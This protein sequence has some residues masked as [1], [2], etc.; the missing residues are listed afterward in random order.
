[1]EGGLEEGGGRRKK[2]RERKERKGTNH[3]LKLTTSS[4]VDTRAVFSTIS[5]ESSTMVGVSYIFGQ[6]KEKKG[7]RKELGTQIC[8]FADGAEQQEKGCGFRIETTCCDAMPRSACSV[9][10]TTTG[11]FQIFSTGGKSVRTVSTIAD[12]VNTIGGTQC[13]ITTHVVVQLSDEG[14]ICC[15]Q[16]KPSLLTALL[17][18]QK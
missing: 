10:V 1:M 15:F 13:L 18:K 6:K 3:E 4:S 2:E 8:R 5:A 7:I 14:C 12:C 16:E 9:C 17:R 11:K